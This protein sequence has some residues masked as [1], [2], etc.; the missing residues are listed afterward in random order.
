MLAVYNV[1][2]A[3]MLGWVFGGITVGLLTVA[4]IAIWRLK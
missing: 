4:A 1:S 3:F 2:D